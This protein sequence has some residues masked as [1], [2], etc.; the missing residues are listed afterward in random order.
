MAPIKFEDSIKE[1]LEKRRLEPS[2]EAWN[3]LSEKLVTNT[4][5]SS[6]KNVC[7]DRNCCQSGWDFFNDLHVL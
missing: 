2:T 3:R 5:R 1:K 4:E 6:K 7:M